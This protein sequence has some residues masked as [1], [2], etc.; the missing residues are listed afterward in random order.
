MSYWV[1]EALSE[2]HHQRSQRPYHWA[3]R[4][5]EYSRCWRE[6]PQPHW[7]IL[8]SA[9]SASG[10]SVKHWIPPSQ[11]PETTTSDRLGTQASDT[12]TNYHYIKGNQLK[13]K[14]LGDKMYW[15]IHPL[16]GPGISPVWPTPFSLLFL[17]SSH[18]RLQSISMLKKNH[19][20]MTTIRMLLGNKVCSNLLHRVMNGRSDSTWCVCVYMLLF[21]PPESTTHRWGQQPSTVDML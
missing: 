16:A 10:R 11:T 2:W 18:Q 8:R 12:L 3:V 17:I 6:T 13:R 21:L 15:F 19:Q 5:H 7:R 9:D 4:L 1:S 20:K 14:L